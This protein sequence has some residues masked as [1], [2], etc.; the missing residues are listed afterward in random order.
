MDNRLINNEGKEMVRF[1]GMCINGKFTF[2]ATFDNVHRF[3]VVEAIDFAG[4]WFLYTLN[5][6]E[7]DR[8]ETLCEIETYIEEMDT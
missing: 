4:G 6:L 2:K 3:D 1:E 5:G 8:F 7:I